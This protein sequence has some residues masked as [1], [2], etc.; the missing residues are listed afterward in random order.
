MSPRRS[1]AWEFC[2]CLSKM[3]IRDTI[4]VIIVVAILV[5][6]MISVV[7]AVALSA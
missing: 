3:T 5:L 1:P 4:A 2:P 6:F 7:L